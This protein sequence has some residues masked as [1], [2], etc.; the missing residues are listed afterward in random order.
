MDI[1]PSNS[2]QLYDIAITNAQIPKEGP[3]ALPLGI[4]FSDTKLIFKLNF[5]LTM[6]QQYMSQVQGVY[7][8]NAA[9][10]EPVT[11]N[12]GVINQ[13]LEFPANS[14]GYIPLLVPKNAELTVAS[15][16]AVTVRMIFLNVP[17]PAQIWSV[18]QGGA[19]YQA[20]AD[21]TTD[22]LG[23]DGGAVGDLLTAVTIIPLT[24]S[25]GAVTITDGANS[26]VIFAG[27]ASSVSNL[28]PFIVPVEATSR[29]AGWEITT[30]EDVT[31]L[32]TGE[33]T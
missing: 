33:F 9:N 27:G 19:V 31:V 17:V 2:A 14:Q 20:V 23:P 4:P 18:G 13:T 30:G 12:V 28:V 25:P 26:I 29:L 7:V 21:E 24:T 10:S 6:G 3:K 15:E 32:A 22:P 1:L 8:D 5:L 11:F 16:G